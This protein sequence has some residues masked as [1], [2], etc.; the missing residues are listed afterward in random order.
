MAVPTKKIV[1]GGILG[2]G[3]IASVIMWVVVN[4]FGAE[5]DK[6]LQSKI[7]KYKCPKCKNEFQ[8]TM[9]EASKILE[10]SGGTMPCPKCKETET[11]KEGVKVRMGGSNRRFSS[12]DDQKPAG[13]GEP[14]AKKKPAAPAGG[15]QKEEK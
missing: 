8:M 10:T 15:M 11:I 13:E 14:E 4:P 5:V 12:D 9:A 7:V 1:V 2:V 6:S 3:L